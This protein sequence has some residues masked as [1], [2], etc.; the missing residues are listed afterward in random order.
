MEQTYVALTQLRE[1]ER[2]IFE[3]WYHIARQLLP[4]FVLEVVTFPPQL[5]SLVESYERHKTPGLSS[6]LQGLRLAYD[7]FQRKPSNQSFGRLSV[8]LFNL[9]KFVFHAKKNLDSDYLVRVVKTLVMVKQIQSYVIKGDQLKAFE[10]LVE[11]AQ[12]L[13]GSPNGSDGCQFSE[14]TN[15]PLVHVSDGLFGSYQVGSV[16]IQSPFD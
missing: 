4:T 15:S 5:V 3:L 13:L 14:T 10:S 12:G 1:L 11:L 8:R 6:H 9:H 16:L 2:S 7:L